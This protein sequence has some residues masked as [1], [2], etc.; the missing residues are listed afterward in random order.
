MADN[1][2]VSW[3]APGA[4]NFVVAYEDDFSSRSY[5]V[6]STPSSAASAA[7]PAPSTATKQHVDTFT[8]YVKG[9][10]VGERDGYDL[11]ATVPVPTSPYNTA[12]QPVG[13]DGWRQIV[14]INKNPHGRVWTRIDYFD[15][16]GGNL[17]EFGAQGGYAC[18]AQPIGEEVTSGKVVLR[19]DAHLPGKY[20]HNYTFGNTTCQRLAAALG[21]SALR[22]SLTAAV[23][24]NTAGGGGI[25]LEETDGVPHRLADGAAVCIGR[26][27]HRGVLPVGLRLRRTAQVQFPDQVGVRQHQDMEGFLRRRDDG[28]DHWI[29]R[30]G[31]GAGVFEAD[32]TIRAEGGNQ[33]LSIG[34]TS[35]S[36]HAARYTTSLGKSIDRGIVTVT[37]D[38]RPP[39]HWFGASGGSVFVTLGNKTLEQSEATEADAGRKWYRFV[40]KVKIADGTYG[41]SVYDMGTSHPS[42]ESTKGAL[43]G[44]A[45][46]LYMMNPVADGISSLDIECR[47]VSSTLGETGNDPLQAQIDNIEV[48]RTPC[49]F[50]LIVK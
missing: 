8:S 10:S 27:E 24:S 6:L 25:Y 21:S 19:V 49:G 46:G 1:I 23:A 14:P 40:A 2:R 18:L 13:V 5:T 33:Y 15:G 30:N 26:S 4:D 42:P 41:I 38:M 29:R 3:K 37:A 28:P 36:G 34:R 44:S 16:D 20:P 9:K 7:Y 47:A 31:N 11:F 32:A 17:L 22:D 35:G 43:V 50:T 48:T 39:K 12:L 45:S